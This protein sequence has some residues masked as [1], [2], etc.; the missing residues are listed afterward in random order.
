MFSLEQLAQD[1]QTSPADHAQAVCDHLFAAIL[2]HQE[3]A[4]RFDDITLVTV[5][6]NLR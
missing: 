2:A 4:P 3:N 1:F 5:C 6:A